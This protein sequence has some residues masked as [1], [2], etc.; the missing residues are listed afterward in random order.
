MELANF[1]PAPTFIDFYMSKLVFSM[2]FCCFSCFSSGLQW[3]G[4]S[5]HKILIWRYCK[6]SDKKVQAA[7]SGQPRFPRH[8][9]L[10]MSLGTVLQIAISGKDLSGENYYVSDALLFCP[11][12]ASWSLLCKSVIKDKTLLAMI[13]EKA[14]L[15]INQGIP[16]CRVES[17]PSVCITGWQ[18]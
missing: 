5:A 13:K 15:I 17:V 11:A 9:L 10:I 12:I 8:T 3:W 6:Y 18:S 4:V 7:F 2:R 1:R 14:F 16:I